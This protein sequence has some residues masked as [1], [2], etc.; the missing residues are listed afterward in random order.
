MFAIFLDQYIWIE[1]FD[2]FKQIMWFSIFFIV[3][4]N[5]CQLAILNTFFIY[6]FSTYHVFSCF[7]IYFFYM[8][9][10]GVVFEVRIKENI[11]N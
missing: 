2:I 11:S 4:L 6:N 9:M 5:E 10:L 3:A 7:W 8:E 1:L